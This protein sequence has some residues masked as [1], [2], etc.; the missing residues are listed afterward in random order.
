MKVRGVTVSN[1]PN[2]TVQMDGRTGTAKDSKKT[3]ITKS[4][5][6]WRAINP[7]PEEVLS[8]KYPI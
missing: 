1:I 6:L 5:K 7:H 4:R 2:D 3:Y 8:A